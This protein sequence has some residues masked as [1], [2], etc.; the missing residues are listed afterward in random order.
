M[1][2]PVRPFTLATFAALAILGCAPQDGTGSS[3]GSSSSSGSRSSSDGGDGGATTTAGKACLDT[4]AV[5]A[6]AA[7]RCGGNYDAEYAAFVR[8]VAGGDCNLV[9]IRN[10]SELRTQCFPAMTRTTCDE[11]RNQRFAPGCAEQIIRSR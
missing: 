1:S 4:A 5:F 6:S 2:L 7:A 10:E 9:S 3:S 11:L 8:D